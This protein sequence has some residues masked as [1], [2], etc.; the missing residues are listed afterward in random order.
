MRCRLFYHLVWTTQGREP[1]IDLECARFLC[2]T[3]RPIAQRYRASILEIGV[4]STHLHLLIRA[5]PMTDLSG[6][7]GRM[8]GV[9]SRVA[10]RD[11][12][13]TLNWADG[14]DLETVTPGDEE[15]IRHYL[16][17]QPFRH[18]DDAIPGWT[19]DAYRL[20]STMMPVPRPSPLGRHAERRL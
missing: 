10:K 3:L 14:Y 5:H 9:T 8:K 4:V 18:P 15:R 6:M 20:E 12:V 11:G 19:G 17:A 13:A 1:Q 7:V 16:R 2:R